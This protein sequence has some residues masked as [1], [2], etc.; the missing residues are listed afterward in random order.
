MKEEAILGLYRHENDRSSKSGKSRLVKKVAL[1][2][3]KKELLRT[4]SWKETVI[5]KIKEEGYDVL[6]VSVAHGSD[7]DL[8]VNIVVSVTR[9]PPRFGERKAATV[10]KRSVQDG[11]VKTGKTMAHKRRQ[12]QAARGK[13]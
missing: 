12:E 10:G 1:G 4:R 2:V 8:D 6:S 3:E 11:P 7:A 13:R 9:K 5:A